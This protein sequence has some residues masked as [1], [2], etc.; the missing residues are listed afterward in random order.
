MKLS[1]R[2]FLKGAGL[3]AGAAAVA[4]IAGCSPAATSSTDSAAADSANA[5]ESTGRWSWSTAP[6]PIADE[7]LSNTYDCD[8]CV[9]G[10]GMAGCSSLYYALQ[11]GYNVVALQ[12][13]ETI[14]PGGTGFG[15]FNTSDPEKWGL[16]KWDMQTLM[17]TI[18]DATDGKTN[19]RLVK[20]TM[21]KSGPVAEW[22]AANIPGAELSYVLIDGDH[23]G[24]EWKI[25]GFESNYGGFGLVC[26]WMTQN[27]A[28]SGATILYSTPA[29][30]LATDDSGAVTGVYG[31]AEDGSYVKVNT[32][33]GVIMACGDISN[34]QEMLECYYPF[35]IGLDR[36]NA[37]EGCDGDATKMGMW[38]G[39]AIE[40][41][42]ANTQI[43]LDLAGSAH[44]K[45]CPWLH[46]NINGERFMNEN[47][48]YENI[49]NAVRMQP[50]H[51]AWQIIDSHML[52]HVADYPRAFHPATT[53]EALDEA[54]ANGEGYKAD[55]IAELAE[56]IG[57][58]P[59]TLQ[60]TVDRFNEMVDAGQDDDFCMD[61]QYLQWAGI[62][63]AP[64][65]AFF[66]KNALLCTDAGL[67]CNDKLE[68]LNEDGEVIPGLYAA[69]NAQGA[70]FG[71]DYPAHFGGFSVGR[72]VTG[73][74]LAVKSAA[75]TLDEEL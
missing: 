50:D 19:T 32:S 75:G 9:V 40:T 4:G 62:K 64:F 3:A 10:L 66:Y 53:Q 48:P 47:Q 69:G 38:I 27:A 60:E 63:D 70:F 33:M 17:Q 7:D 71:Y 36:Q 72:A 26:D 2:N 11:K 13:L 59:D 39:A 43:H 46:V 45:G 21:E 6:D 15:A 5:S 61:P 25:D 14:H 65:Y 20:R 42:P 55:T 74:V 1:R 12:K 41:T 31:Q 52:E 35:G 28:E 30:Q 34:D 73:G 68:V 44:F 18:T 57:L 8:I 67:I 22:F 56:A 49:C 24:T 16:E 37:R 51:T 54:I 29:V 58:D 23:F